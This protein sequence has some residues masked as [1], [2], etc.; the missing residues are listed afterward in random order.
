MYYVYIIKSLVNKHYYKGFTKDL[1]RRLREHANGQTSS[2]KSYGRFKL[3]H[4][5]V[6]NSLEDAVRLEKFFKSGFGR[7]II[8]EID[9]TLGRVAEWYT[10]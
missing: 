7:E 5:E 9:Q 8:K 6:C 4:V 3:I 2:I 1:D 10:R